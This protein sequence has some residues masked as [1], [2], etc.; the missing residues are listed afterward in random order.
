[1]WKADSDKP[2]TTC[3]ESIS[4]RINLEMIQDRQKTPLKQI[5]CT[6]RNAHQ[7]V[8]KPYMRAITQGITVVLLINE[9]YG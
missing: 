1:M 8:V 2:K 9:V 5:C 3:K 4:K 7:H 6:L